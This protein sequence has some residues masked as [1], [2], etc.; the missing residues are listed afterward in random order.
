[1]NKSDISANFR[2]LL[3]I[4]DNAWAQFRKTE[5]EWLDSLLKPT[6]DFHA[7][8]KTH[9]ASWDALEDAMWTLRSRRA[10]QA[11]W[12]AITTLEEKWRDRR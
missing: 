10:N 4:A 11:E 8:C 5:L 3:V 12:D 1:M 2:D 6:A 7:A 9:D